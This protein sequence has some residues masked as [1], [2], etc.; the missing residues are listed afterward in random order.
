MEDSDLFINQ[1]FQSLPAEFPS[2]F[3]V[4][5]HPAAQQAAAHLQTRLDDICPPE[6][7]FA[8]PDGGKMFG[9]LVVK[10]RSGQAGYLSAYSG[11]L[12]GNWRNSGFVPPVFSE[13]NRNRLLLE[14]EAKVVDLTRQIEQIETNS[15]YRQL[16]NDWQQ[17]IADSELEIE[18]L[19]QKQVEHKQLR[20]QVR[21]ECDL[22][23][24]QLFELAAQ[25]RMDKLFMKMLKTRL[26]AMTGNYYD[27]L[28]DFEL[29]LTQL[30]KLRKRLSAKLQK[31]LFEGY[32]LMCFSGK[33]KSLLALFDDQMPPSGA[34]DC[35]A[36]KLLHY[37]N[38]HNYRP[39]ALSEFWWGASPAGAMRKH[40]RYYPSCRS[41]CR[42]LLPS[43]LAGL[44][45]T[46]PTHEMPVIFSTEIPHQ[47]YEDDDIVVVDKP[48]GL[49]S[50][51]GK[52]LT[53]SV[54]ARL[55]QRYPEVSGVMLLHRLDQATSGVMIAA[56]H[57]VAYKSLQHQF[58]NRTVTKE[59]TAVLDGSL[60]EDKGEVTLPLRLDIYDRPRQIVC[61]ERGKASLTRYSVTARQN[62]TTRVQFYPHTGRT[63]Q[64]RVHAAH[65]QGLDCPILGDELYGRPAE[66]LYLHAAK[67]TVT[68]PVKGTQMTF[69]SA[70][71]F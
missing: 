61:F 8:A 43:M 10:D 66:R 11:M 51:P 32:Q 6:H 19:K 20:H 3:D 12:G 1:Q 44:S 45:V 63:H 64:L 47:I 41:R 67:L 17:N 46:V 42:R 38:S 27:E 54:E 18:G 62:N 40:G 68:H 55:K 53:D 30:K 60:A 9:V 23:E 4:V 70:V 36:T 13:S 26:E 2:P 58:Q 71:D 39:I 37:A 21:Q 33:E 16:K 31:Q 48:A 7:L 35:A 65:P 69:S 24:E 34:G 56:K 52:V 5:P 59:Y 14:G 22:N 49:L 28:H 15:E 25:S 57:P 50:V 29:R